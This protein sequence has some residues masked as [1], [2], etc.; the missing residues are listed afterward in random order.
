MRQTA[1]IQTFKARCEGRYNVLNTVDRDKDQQRTA[2][3]FYFSVL[4]YV[5]CLALRLPI[6]EA[7]GSNF[8]AESG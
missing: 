8:D 1:Y 7:S 4:V 5:E 6:W 3:K 2:T